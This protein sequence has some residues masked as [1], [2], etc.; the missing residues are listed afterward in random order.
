MKENEQ[1]WIF[2]TYFQIKINAEGL[3]NENLQKSNKNLAG[4]ALRVIII[5]NS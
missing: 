2:K 1:K 5:F 3:K 4:A